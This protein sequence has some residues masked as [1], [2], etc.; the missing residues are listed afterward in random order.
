MLEEE[1]E[2]ESFSGLMLLPPLPLPLP[3]ERSM[4]LECDC[5]K[6]GELLILG[7]CCDFPLVTCGT[8]MDPLFFPLTLSR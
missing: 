8:D 1:E 6:F 2:E 3:V 7:S 4:G 5:G